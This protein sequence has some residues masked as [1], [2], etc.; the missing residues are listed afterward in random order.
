MHVC[1][2]GLSKDEA[3]EASAFNLLPLIQLPQR[4]VVWS[5]RA[6]GCVSVRACVCVCECLSVFLAGSRS[7]SLSLSFLSLLPFPLGGT[8]P[9]VF[10]C[11]WAEEGRKRFTLASWVSKGWCNTLRKCCGARRGE[12]RVRRGARM[13]QRQARPKKKMK[14]TYPNLQAKHCKDK[15]LVDAPSNTLGPPIPVHPSKAAKQKQQ[16]R[17][18]LSSACLGY[19]E[20]NYLFS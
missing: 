4:W 2:R 3:L 9:P 6:A 10:S 1:K 16:Q 13:A 18:R 5:T 8:H 20:P 7:S 14:I 15:V 11:V 19:P 12:R 17:G